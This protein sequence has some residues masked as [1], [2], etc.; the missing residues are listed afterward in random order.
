MP[1]EADEYCGDPSLDTQTR[2]AS[3]LSGDYT[4]ELRNLPPSIPSN[5]L[6]SFEVLVAANLDIPTEQ[7]SIIVDAG[8]PQHAH[9]MTVRPR[10]S[11]NASNGTFEVE[12]MMFHMPGAWDLT[13][14]VV[15]GP[16]TERVTFHVEAR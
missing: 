1:G 8:M 12:G 7:L 9:G 10:A 11:F 15:D 16:Y 2:T 3:T 14:D 6:F 13:I 5:D 4:V